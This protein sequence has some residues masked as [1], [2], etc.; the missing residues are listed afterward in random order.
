MAA[1]LVSSPSSVTGRPA[2]KGALSASSKFSSSR[3]A[4]SSLYS[5]SSESIVRTIGNLCLTSAMSFAFQKKGILP[6]SQPHLD[7]PWFRH[8]PEVARGH[9]SC[10]SYNDNLPTRSL[11][12][13]AWWNN[14][15]CR[16]VAF[17]SPC[18][19][20]NRLL[21]CR[22][23]SYR[24]SNHANWISTPYPLDA[25]FDACPITCAISWNSKAPSAMP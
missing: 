3:E 18:H 19:R 20:N 5:S 4:S 13:R 8:F 16:L 24:P 15:Q 7:L 25:T 10:L 9:R 2:S 14:V 11:R 1:S 6:P 17:C 22:S 12:H 21:E 23:F